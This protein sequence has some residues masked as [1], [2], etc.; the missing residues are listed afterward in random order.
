MDRLLRTSLLPRIRAEPTASSMRKARIT[1]QP[2][3]ARV[4]LV[5]RNF[6]AFRLLLA[7]MVIVQHF[8]AALAPEFVAT[9]ASRYE[10]GSVAVLAFF[11]LSGFVIMEAADQ[12]YIGRPR[13]FLSNRLLRVFPH[14][15]I[16]C[17]VAIV[18]FFLLGEVDWLRLP[19]NEQALPAAAALSAKNILWN[20]VGVLPLSDRY[21]NFNFLTIAWA[22]RVEMAFYLAVAAALVGAAWLAKRGILPARKAFRASALALVALSAPLFALSIFGKGLAMFQYLPYFVFGGALY[23]SVSEGGRTARALASAAFACIVWQ[24]LSLPAHHPVLGYARDVHAQ[25]VLLAC[26]IAIITLLAHWPTRRFQSVDR[27]LGDLTYP[28]YMYHRDVALLTASLCSSLSFAGFSIAVI[29]SVAVAW[30]AHGTLDPVVDR[31][32]HRIRGQVV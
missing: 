22:V 30:L 24:F 3:Q 25:F 7:A 29:L 17:L 13:A 26:L 14:F 1:Q 9:T 5:Y 16:A 15:L 21:M 32:R 19:H 20:L 6:G 8:M 2:Q 11:A 4:G 18:F 31:L 10:I 27:S 12:L 23:Y 28:L